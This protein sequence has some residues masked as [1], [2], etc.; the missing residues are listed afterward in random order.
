MKTRSVTRN[1]QELAGM[2]STGPHH[3]GFDLRPKT[4]GTAHRASKPLPKR[5]NLEEKTTHLHTPATRCSRTWR[6]DPRGTLWWP[7]R[8]LYTSA[9]QNP[10][11]AEMNN[12][13]RLRNHTARTRTTTTSNGYDWRDKRASGPD[14]TTS[15]AP[16]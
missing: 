4:W 2:T 1:L 10:P 12:P 9:N 3:L 7:P 5:S 15:T 13:D 14:Y 6:T 8:P 11:T 16:R